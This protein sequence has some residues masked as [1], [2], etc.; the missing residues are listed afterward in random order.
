[1][2]GKLIS[3]IGVK[4]LKEDRYIFERDKELKQL[5]SIITSKDDISFDI[6]KEKKAQIKNMLHY[7]E[8]SKVCSTLALYTPDLRS[9]VMYGSET[10]TIR[11]RLRIWKNKNVEDNIWAMKK[12]RR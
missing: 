4:D 12:R 10:W 2:S 11:K 5:E 7:I 8:A 3:R 9:V 1:M 6:M